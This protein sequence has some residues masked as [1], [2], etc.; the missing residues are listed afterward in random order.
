[1]VRVLEVLSDKVKQFSLERHFTSN[2]S[3]NFQLSRV[4][5]TVGLIIQTTVLGLIQ[6]RINEG[7]QPIS[8]CT[9]GTS[10]KFWDTTDG[11]SLFSPLGVNISTRSEE[12][13]HC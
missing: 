12:V 7:L 1:M 6:V 3:S 10:L 8:V 4:N 5:S 11:P 13:H 2:Q 9:N